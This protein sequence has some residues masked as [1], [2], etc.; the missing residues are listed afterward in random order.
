MTTTTTTEEEKKKQEKKLQEFKDELKRQPYEN[1]EL[2]E[3]LCSREIDEFEGLFVR[4][5]I[6]GDFRVVNTTFKKK[7]HGLFT[8]DWK[9]YDDSCRRSDV[10]DS[11]DP[12]KNIFWLY[13]SSKED[14]KQ[15]TSYR[16]NEKIAEFVKTTKEK[17]ERISELTKLGHVQFI[18]KYLASNQQN[19]KKSP[20]EVMEDHENKVKKRLKLIEMI[21]EED[22]SN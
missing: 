11:R 19:H 6:N 5:N 18:R 4:C 2:A 22:T 21:L 9:E 15:R 20:V 17:I 13:T 14:L 8:Y 12:E 3:L 7:N 10:V 1:A 16:N